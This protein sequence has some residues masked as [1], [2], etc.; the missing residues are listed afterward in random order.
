VIVVDASVVATALADDDVDGRRARERLRGET[1]TAPELLDL[2]VVSVIR[3]LRATRRLTPVR[4]E[5]ALTDLRDLQLERAPHRPL[6]GRCWELRHNLSPYDAAYVALAE[7]F[8]AVLLTADAR[9]AAAPGP[10]CDIELLASGVS[11]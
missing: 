4:A 8:G 9:L 1:L 3:R 2:E 5:Q 6:L 11:G 10:I 7:A